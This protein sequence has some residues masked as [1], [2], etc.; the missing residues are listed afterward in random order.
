MS[1][2]ERRITKTSLNHRQ[3]YNLSPTRQS[4]TR[5]KNH[6]A[7]EQPTSTPTEQEPLP[8][9]LFPM[10]NDFEIPELDPAM[11]VEKLRAYT[12]LDIFA[13][14]GTAIIA[15][16]QLGRRCYSMEYEPRYAD[17]ILARWEKLTGRRAVKQPETEQQATQPCEP[18]TIQ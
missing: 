11:P 9:A 12:V 18:V 1:P 5:N 17:A 14:S 13:G 7:D 8:D 10:D 4:K 3:N 2:P 16:E 15:C 6:M